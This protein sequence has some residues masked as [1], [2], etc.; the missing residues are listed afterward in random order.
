M[1][2]PDKAFPAGGNR[3]FLA[4]ILRAALNCRIRNS[5]PCSGAFHKTVFSPFG[6]LWPV[7]KPGMKKS[8]EPQR[9]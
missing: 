7:L 1:S 4:R 2:S 5:G 9:L 6:I 3:M 8:L